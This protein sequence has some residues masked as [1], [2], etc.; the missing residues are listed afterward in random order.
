L[1]V[2]GIAA[3]L[4]TGVLSGLLGVGGGVVMVPIMVLGLGLD[5]HT[6][7]GTSLAVIVPTALVGAGTHMRQGRIALAEAGWLGLGGL[8][9]AAGG[10]AFA[11]GLGGATLQRV[12]GA[13]LILVAVQMFRR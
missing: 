12:F 6:A 7:Q 2:I 13:F 1:V 11:L 9:G 4:L 5:Q 8:A 3:G 10:T